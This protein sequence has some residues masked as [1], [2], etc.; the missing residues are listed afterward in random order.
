MDTHDLDLSRFAF[1]DAVRTGDS[2]AIGQAYALDATLVA[3]GSEVVRG[4]AAIE[5][6]W[7]TGVEI[8]I[9]DLELAVLD[10]HVVGD[11]ALE[12]GRY[13]MHAPPQ[14]GPGPANHGSYLAVHR[15]EPDGRW[16]RLAEMLS[17]DHEE[18]VR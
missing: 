1:R 16:R 12:A 15:V 13:V 10:L 18:G 5:Q 17:P 2:A 3:P 9:E 11:L 8:G 4:R 7:R 14:G 6:F